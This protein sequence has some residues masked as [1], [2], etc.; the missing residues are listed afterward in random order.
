MASITP[1]GRVAVSSET[2][3]KEMVNEHQVMVLHR[4]LSAFALS[5]DLMNGV[6]L[7]NAIM[8]KDPAQR[9]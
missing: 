9:R 4:I 2:R 3:S 7:T 8:S 5:I 6:P 1:L